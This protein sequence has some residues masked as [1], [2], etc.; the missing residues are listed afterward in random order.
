MNDKLNEIQEVL[1]TIK[2]QL[3]LL[4]VQL[5]ALKYIKDPIRKDSE[6]TSHKRTI[7]H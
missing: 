2:E 5:E 6:R 1:D 3:R 4:Y 7:K